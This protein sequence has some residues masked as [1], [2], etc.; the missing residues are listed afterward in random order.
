VPLVDDKHYFPPYDA[1]PIVRRDAIAR[2]PQLRDALS[3]LANKISAE[4]MRHLNSEVD[5]NQR[6]P[7]AVIR[8]FRASKSL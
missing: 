1:V 8:A 6:D 4:E 3:D 2:F 5:A 7:A